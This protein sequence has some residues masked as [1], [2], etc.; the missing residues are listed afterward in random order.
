VIEGN[1]FDKYE[2]RVGK[3]LVNG[4]DAN[5]PMIQAGLAWHYKEYERDQ[6]MTDRKLYSDAEIAAR[7]ARLGLWR[8]N[9]PTP[10][11]EWRHGNKSADKQKMAA[12]QSAE[13]PCGGVTL[14]TGSR[15]G[16][17]CVKPNGKKQYQ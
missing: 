5:L 2:R 15:G 13:C 1:K 4:I 3:V 14:C 10:P 6:S 9:A 17:F 12:Q 8:D 16:Q 7:S 11:W